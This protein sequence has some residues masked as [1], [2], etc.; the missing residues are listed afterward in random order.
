MSETPDSPS[1][2]GSYLEEVAKNFKLKFNLT[3]DELQQLKEVT[4]GHFAQELPRIRVTN[5][6]T[7]R[8]TEAG[9]IELKEMNEYLSS[10]IEPSILGELQIKCPAR[11]QHHH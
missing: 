1:E 10:K 9:V 8:M 6:I 7:T 2:P 5:R 4:E 3:A 11:C